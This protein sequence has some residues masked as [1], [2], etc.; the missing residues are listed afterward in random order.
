MADPSGC[1]DYSSNVMILG[2][3]AGVG[4]SGSIRFLGGPCR[5]FYASFR[6]PPPLLALCWMVIVRSMN[7]EQ[8]LQHVEQVLSTW[9]QVRRRPWNPLPMF[10]W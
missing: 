8:K 6:D 2:E 1:C 5:E 3:L 7:F 4:A 9:H 10:K